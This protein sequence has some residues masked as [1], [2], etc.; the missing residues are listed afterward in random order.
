MRL[1]KNLKSRLLHQ[2]PMDE[3]QI[4]LTY[5]QACKHLKPAQ[6]FA[7]DFVRLVEAH[8]GIGHRHE[9]KDYDPIEN[10]EK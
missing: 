4:L 7:K 9:V 3:D 1:I 8:H 5:M 10:V 6:L 2:A